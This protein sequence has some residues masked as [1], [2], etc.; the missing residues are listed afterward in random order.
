LAL[1]VLL[2]ASCGRPGKEE[3]QKLA[4]HVIDVI[5]E[6]VGEPTKE[7]TAAAAAWKKSLR[8][9]KK[10]SLRGTLVERCTTAMTKIQHRCYMGAKTEAALAA[11]DGQ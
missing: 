4:E 5:T 3:C 8:A 9:G 7:S 1:V 11:C 6:P 10:S 2:V